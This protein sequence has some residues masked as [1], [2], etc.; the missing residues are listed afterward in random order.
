MSDYKTDRD[1]FDEMLRDHEMRSES[2]ERERLAALRLKVDAV[3]K[4]FLQNRDFRSRF[5]SEVEV[6]E[7][8]IALLKQTGTLPA[9]YPPTENRK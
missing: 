6:R 3:V 4:G 8:A 9:D 7:A 1:R 5:R 2:A